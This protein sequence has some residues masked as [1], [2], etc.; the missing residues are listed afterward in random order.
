MNYF[1][2]LQGQSHGEQKIMAITN[3]HKIKRNAFCNWILD[4]ATVQNARGILS[5][6]NLISKSFYFRSSEHDKWFNQ[7]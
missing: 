3:G 1:T 5:F 7:A 6:F 4:T 2:T